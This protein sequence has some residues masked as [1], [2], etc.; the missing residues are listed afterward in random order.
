M[1]TFST[2]IAFIDMLFNMLILM[3]TMFFLSLMLVNPVAKD[4][5]VTPTVAMMIE[6]SWDDESNTDIDL[7]VKTPTGD[8]TYYASKENPPAFLERD[9]LGW[10]ND[11][12]ILNGEEVIVERNYEVISLSDL[13]D[14]EYFVSV[15]GFSIPEDAFIDVTVSAT[16]MQPFSELYFNTIPVKDHQ[17]VGV[18]SFVVQDGAVIDVYDTLDVKLRPS[19][20]TSG[21]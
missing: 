8:V 2:N 20:K 10:S 7:Y 12:Y 15:H 11:K 3:T 9:D 16:L 1:K 14:G 13:P 6:M 19:A 18:L 21:P 4:G 17:E 5:I